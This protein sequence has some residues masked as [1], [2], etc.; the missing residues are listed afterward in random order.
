MEGGKGGDEDG[1]MVQKQVM[2]YK[3]VVHT[4]LL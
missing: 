4:V 3:A 2:L 1:E